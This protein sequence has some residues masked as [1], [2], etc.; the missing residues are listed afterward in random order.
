MNIIDKAISAF[1]PAAALKR[2]GARQRLEILTNSGYSNYG[3]NHVKKF[4]IGWQSHSGDAQSDIIDNLSTLRQR[5]RDLYMGVPIATGALK[6]FR[7]NVVGVGLTLKSTIDPTVLKITEEQAREIERLIEREFDLWADS[8]NCDAERLDNFYELQQ[9]AF[10]NWLMSGDT[11]V[12]LPQNTRPNSPYDL[13]VQLI[14]ADRVSN[15]PDAILKENITGGVEVNERG[16]VTAY[17]I[18]NKHPDQFTQTPPQWTRVK[19]Y[20]NKTGRRNVLH[21]MNRERVG[22][23]RGVPLLSPVIESLKQLGQYTQAELTA[24][25]VSGLFAV[26]IEKKNAS[27]EPPIDGMYSRAEQLDPDDDRSIELAPGIV[28]DL[29]DGEEAK[30]VTPGRPNGN[31]DPFVIAI[32]RQ[33]GAALELPY[34]LLVKNFDASYSA[35]RGALLEAWKG[36]KMYRAWLSNDFCQPIFEEWLDEAVA[37]GRIAAPGYFSDPA[38]RKAYGTAEWHGPAQGTLDPVK[39]VTAAVIRVKNGFSTHERESMEMNGTDFHKNIMTLKREEELLREV[40]PNVTIKS[41]VQK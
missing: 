29:E 22:Q 30:P 37:K 11:F 18:C 20:G 19:A 5:S 35:S 26:F 10:L 14:E 23:L 41:T 36:F 21:L 7:T 33:I 24:A 13:R 32:C 17:H 15:P 31:F 28:L 39:E 16:E 3:A 1:A 38:I 25:V 8:E 34:E 27:G 12:M 9:L 2:V 6:T 40:Y 4:A